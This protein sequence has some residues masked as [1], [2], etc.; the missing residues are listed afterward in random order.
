MY[1]AAT[2]FEIPTADFERARRFYETVFDVSFRENPYADM[3][4]KMAIFPYVEGTVGG[5]LVQWEMSR[6]G[7]NG[8]LVYLNAGPDLAVA[9]GRV[10]AAGGKVVVPK[11]LI[12][13]DVGYF[14]IFNDTEGNILGM[15]SMT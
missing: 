13:P 3:P 14:A 1:N 5:A 12:A 6:P 15:H 10:E 8:T 9:L 2:W 7:P 4:G 11:T